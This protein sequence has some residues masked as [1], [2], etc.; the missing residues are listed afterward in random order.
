MKVMVSVKDVWCLVKGLFWGGGLLNVKMKV[1]LWELN[2]D[3]EVYCVA[4]GVAEVSR[5]AFGEG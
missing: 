1:V 4:A 2:V 3:G 5:E